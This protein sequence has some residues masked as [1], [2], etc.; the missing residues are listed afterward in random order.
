MVHLTRRN[1]L[2]IA[3]LLLATSSVAS[4]PVVR[5]FPSGMKYPPTF[6]KYGG[7]WYDSWGFD[8][9]YYDDSDGYMPNIAYETLGSNKELAYSIGEQFKAIYPN[10]VQRAEAI[11]K[12]VQRWTDY[13]YDSDNVVMDGAPQDEWAWNADEMAHMFNQTTN[14]VAIGDCEDMAFLCATLYVSAGYDVAMVLAPEHVALLIW[15]PEYPNANYYWDLPNDGRGAGWIWVEA[16][17]ENNPLGWTPPDFN[18][19]NWYSY[20][21][22]MLTVDVDYSPQQPQAGDAVDVTTLVTGVGA[23]ISQVWLNYSVGGGAPTALNMELKGTSYTATIPKQPKGTEVKFQVSATDSEGNVGESD[24]LSYTVGV[25]VSGC[26]I[27]TATY[28]SELAP[29]VQLLRDFRD[30]IAMKTFAGSSFMAVFNAWYY[31][32]SP[33]VAAQIAPDAN[34]RSMM[35]VVLQ[36][37]LD[38]LQVATAAFWLFSFNGEFAI[39]L[40]GLVAASLIGL[41]YLAPPVTVA[42]IGIKRHRGTLR[43]PRTASL[44]RVLAVPWVASMVLMLAGEV[45]PVSLLMMV[46]SGAFVLLTVLIVACAIS[47]QVARI[48]MRR[49]PKG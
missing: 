23:S 34:A 7:E 27:A 48:V 17:G 46:A 44:L 5:A 18:D 39:F 25:P 42:L 11:L 13:G 38:I 41:V 1:L 26:V 28:G 30:A 29:Q 45:F 49:F 9:N 43:L 35:Q 10:D 16:T 6:R 21:L 40:A 36:P 12:F 14:K 8:R 31:S 15:L 4:T 3:V 24:V 37:L 19:G 33:P 22:G 20:L 47:L 32:W 2:A